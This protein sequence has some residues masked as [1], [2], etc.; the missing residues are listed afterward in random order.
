MTNKATQQIIEQLKDSSHPP[1]VLL[2]G[3][4]GIGKTHLIDNEL[5]PLIESNPQEFGDYHYVSAFGIKSVTEFQDQIVS[6]YISSQEEGSKYLDGLTRLSGKLARMC[7]ADASEAGV[8]QGVISGTTGFL[9]QKAIQNMKDITLVVD[10][11]ERLTDEKLISD[12]M[13][14]CLRFAEHN[15]IK[16]I[17]V[18]NATAFQDKTKVEKSFSDV[19][20]LTRTTEELLTIIADIYDG[21]LDAMVEH[22][23]FQTINHAQTKKL[24]INNLRVLQRAVNRTIKLI[25]R[26]RLIEGIDE[27][28][29]AEKLT[30]HIVLIT[31]YGYANK[32]DIDAFVS[33]LESAQK[34]QSHRLAEA[35]ASRNASQNE[36]EELTKDEQQQ[37]VLFDQLTSLL[38]GFACSDT[39]AEYCFTNLIPELSDE[40]FIERF[41][42]PR[43]AKPLD[44][45]KTHSFYSFTSEEEF[46][47]GITQ[48]VDLL[49]TMTNVNWSD[50]ITCCDTYLFMHERGYF[51][52]SNIDELSKRLEERVLEDGV[53]DIDTVNQSRFSFRDYSSNQ[54]STTNFNK[55]IE[56]VN[57]RSKT[58]QREAITDS[59]LK[60]WRHTIYKPQSYIE[61]QPFFHS[62]DN[63]RL[64]EAIAQWSAREVAEF[65]GFMRKRYCVIND[66]E[67][68]LLELPALIQ[69]S[70][71]LDLRREC[72]SGRLQKGVLKEL[73]DEL[74]AA[75]TKIETRQ[76]QN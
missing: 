65:I 36:R 5:R 42:L 21:K 2:D 76:K 63:E 22:T 15:K 14:T 3:A 34:W 72:M 58:K 26:I 60:D 31:L 28:R 74:N 29:S 37:K 33:I 49:F 30:Q 12:I 64:A 43:L 7:G 9:R 19:I 53:I 38:N 41:Q 40:E 25:N 46:E 24:D 71:R 27:R 52:D 48:L 59:F 68:D 18:A 69:L 39:L 13:G 32:L 75:I 51:E 62:I 1:I 50:W 10:D 44:I 67:K 16:I 20:K 57:L 45:F 61:N 6:L 73:I 54:M 11:L 55:A 66:P 47:E 17:A 23:F 8:I 4:W 35:V 70:K 56:E